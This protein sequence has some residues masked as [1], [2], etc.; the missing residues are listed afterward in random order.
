MPT[1]LSKRDFECRTF[2]LNNNRAT[3]YVN[4]CGSLANT[5]EFSGVTANSIDQPDEAQPIN[6]KFVKLFPFTTE[7]Q[8]ALHGIINARDPHFGDFK[9]RLF[10]L[11]VPILGAYNPGHHQLYAPSLVDFVRLLQRVL[12]IPSDGIHLVQA[13][14]LRVC[15]SLNKATEKITRA[16]EPIQNIL[17][18]LHNLQQHIWYDIFMT[19]SGLGF[20]LAH[21]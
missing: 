17:Q 1:R 5:S 9:P 13:Y 16:T 19:S 20:Y 18:P 3:V 2:L 8:A 15:D 14:A 12:G 10:A 7:I 11:P 4:N 21:M 6:C